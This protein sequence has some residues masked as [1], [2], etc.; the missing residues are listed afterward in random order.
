MSTNKKSL[1]FWALSVSNF[2]RIQVF[3]QAL[4]YGYCDYP[5][6]NLKKPWKS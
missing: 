6:I 3:I 5:D 1:L 4:E 2:Y